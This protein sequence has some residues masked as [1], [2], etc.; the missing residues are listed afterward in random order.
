MELDKFDRQLR[1]M[2]L[3]TQNRTLSVSD[4]SD[5]LKMSKRS[6]YRYIEAFRQIGFVIEKEGSFYRIDHRSPFFDKISDGIRFSDAEAI[7][8]N[9]IL[10]A[11]YDNSPQ[12]RHL[13][14]KLSSLYDFNE[15]AKHG[16]DL[17]IA[18]NLST[19]FSAIQL[20]RTVVLCDYISPSSRVMSDRIVEPYLFLSENSEVRCY[21]LS[22][23]MNKTFKI[24]RAR[25]VRMLDTLWSFKDKH[26]PF[27]TDLFH[28]SGEKRYT[29]Q[30]LLGPLA[31]S[32][33]LEECPRAEN[34]IELQDDGRFLLTTEVCS[35]KGVGRFVLGLFDDIEVVN[36]PEFQSYL[37][38]R[39]K[40]LTQKIKR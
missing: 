10:N 30:L 4:I 23:G 9:Q 21:E 24:S 25:E 12:V 32:L 1:L 16:V 15:L 26:A 31:S 18:R 6:V 36:S 35:F 13:R 39:I 2:Q 40:D 38:E 7:T 3:L 8:I 11:V 19:L 20:E 37:N 14:A 17:H 27:Y 34:E 33:L 22:S 29:V 5:Q 28:F